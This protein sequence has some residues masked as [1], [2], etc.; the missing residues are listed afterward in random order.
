LRRLLARRSSWLRIAKSDESAIG[1]IAGLYLVWLL[2][3]L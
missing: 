3:H 1:M 2:S